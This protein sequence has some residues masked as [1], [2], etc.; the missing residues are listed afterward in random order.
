[1]VR[2]TYVQFIHLVLERCS[3]QSQTLGCSTATGDPSRSGLQRIDDHIAFCLFE[4]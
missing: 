4:R 1:M 3:F 2:A